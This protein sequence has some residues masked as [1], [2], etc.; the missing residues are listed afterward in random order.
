MSFDSASL[1]ARDLKDVVFFP[2]RIKGAYYSLKGWN[3]S[4]LD[5]T[6]AC[7]DG[8]DLSD[9]DFTDSTITGASFRGV[10]GLTLEQLSKT[11]NWKEKKMN[12]VALPQR[13]DDAV[14]NYFEG[15]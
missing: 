11:R 10:R 6:G 13:L 1:Y 7:F 4:N 3:L 14:F 9:V 12:D 2:E 8:L 15:F 5:L